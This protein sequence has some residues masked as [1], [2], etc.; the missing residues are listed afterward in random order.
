M[1]P[2]SEI[3]ILFRHRGSRI[4]QQEWEG[5]ISNWIVTRFQMMRLDND[6]IRATISSNNSNQCSTLP[7]HRARRDGRTDGRRSRDLVHLRGLNRIDVLV[8]IT[9]THLGSWALGARQLY[10]SGTGIIVIL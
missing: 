9:N 3:R 1:A 8:S 2:V 4:A 10:Q 6:M 5:R 7:N